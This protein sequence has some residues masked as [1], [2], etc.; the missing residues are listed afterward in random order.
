M[1][2][3]LKRRLLLIVLG[4]V[5]LSWVGSA[6]VTAFYTSRVL[7]AQVDRQLEQ[8]AD[9][10][11][12][13]AQVFERQLEA[14]VPVS[15]PWLT[16]TLEKG[17]EQPMIVDNAAASGV[18]PALNIWLDGRLLAVLRGSPR[19]DRPAEA[20]FHFRERDE[21]RSH[22]RVLARAE[23]PSGLWIV[24]GID[25][26]QAR[27][28]LWGG[29]LRV[30]F[31]LLFLLPL[32]LLV[33]YLGIERGLGPLRAL[34]GQI[35]RRNP[36]ELEPVRPAAA[37]LELEPVVEALNDLLARLAQALESEQRFTANAAHEL[38]T[39]LAAIKTEVQLCQRL[40]PD[41][42]ARARLDRIAARVDRAHHTVEQLL[43]LARLDP[44]SPLPGSPVALD[45]LVQD[46]A[47][48][49]AG[50]ARER[51]LA[52]DL[53]LGDSARVQGNDEALA[54]LVRN[55]LANACRYARSDSP[56]TVR[57]ESGAEQV[58]LAI[59]NDC[60]SLSAGEYER[61]L[62]RFYRRPGSRG[63]GAGLG[64]S[65]AAR[66]AEQHGASLHVGPRNNGR[67]FVATVVFPV[68]SAQRRMG[69]TDQAGVGRGNDMHRHG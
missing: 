23:D 3:S 6:A 68:D 9:L 29:L 33:L 39:P 61:L 69:G 41:A 53:E 48:E 50:L 46:I 20:G 63:P 40:L 30:L 34:A 27:W 7:L 25:M 57:L 36:R 54:I 24:V 8:Y 55:L 19:F 59:A 22:W 65:I 1:S 17:F 32:T 13:I 62:Q 35:S 67:G 28:S 14:G 21:G 66:V 37:P 38:V 64:L 56:V 51:G 52:L 16:G 26:D 42:D 47:A 43:T 4:L 49:T 5:L 15:E 44:D 12:Y 31:P 18:S 11:S 58:S 60:E 45:R 10:V 2:R